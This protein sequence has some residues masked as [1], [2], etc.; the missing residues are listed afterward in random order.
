MSNGCRVPGY[1]AGLEI[2]RERAPIRQRAARVPTAIL[3]EA[4]RSPP[5]GPK[6]PT[7]DDRDGP[8][9]MAIPSAGGTM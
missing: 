7:V 8:E 3:P 2:A 9:M 1:S 4:R 6:L 5:V